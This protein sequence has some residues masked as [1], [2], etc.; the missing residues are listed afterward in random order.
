LTLSG[1]IPPTSSDIPG[2]GPT[3]A[4]T[5]VFKGKGKIY[6]EVAPADSGMAL[7]VLGTSQP[8][9]IDDVLANMMVTDEA[10]FTVREVP[11]WVRP[12]MSFLVHGH[13]LADEAEAKCI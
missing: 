6:L 2:T 3:F 9:E 13:L 12:I 8:M 10:V 4:V 7:S 11:S 5:A 1:V